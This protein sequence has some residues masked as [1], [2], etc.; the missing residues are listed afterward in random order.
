MW[1]LIKRKKKNHTETDAQ[2]NPDIRGQVIKL[3]MMNMFNIIEKKDRQK[4]KKNFRREQDSI[5]ATSR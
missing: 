1:K 3:T 4:G 2:I 5:K